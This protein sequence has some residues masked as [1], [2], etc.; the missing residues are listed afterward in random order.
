MSDEVNHIDRWRANSTEFICFD[1][2][3]F[4]QSW[5]ARTMSIPLDE[6]EVRQ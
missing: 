2:L 5:G 4:L 6:D 1:E 3:L